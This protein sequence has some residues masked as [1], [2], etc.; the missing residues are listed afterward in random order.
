MPI[1]EK[2]KSSSICELSETHKH[3]Y[4]SKLRIYAK[5]R[6]YLDLNKFLTL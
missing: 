1:L 3:A 2:N 6:E 5:I 4:V